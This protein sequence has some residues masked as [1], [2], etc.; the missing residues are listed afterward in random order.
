MTTE[1]EKMLA[2]ELFNSRDP[3]LLAMAHRARALLRRYNATESTDAEAR[4]HLLSE[5][6]GSVGSDVWIEPPFFCD[7]GPHIHL[8]ARSFIHVNAVLLDAATI[9]VGDDTL[10]GPGVQ[11]ITASHP[12]PAAERLVANWVPGS[13][14]APYHTSSA[15]IRIGNRVWIGAGTI[16]TP[17]VTIG[18]NT[19][20]GAGSVV[21]RNIPS[22][23]VAFGQPCR[24]HRELRV[25]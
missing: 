6:L 20:I 24:V 8:G 25:Q 17:G 14:T 12:L 21:T 16:I 10:I 4:Y 9:H 15:P 3:E 1:R 19:T 7:Y 5:L 13:G 23:C 22:D 11:V 18:D 2:G